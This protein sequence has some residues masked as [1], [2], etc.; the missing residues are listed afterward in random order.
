[1]WA[2]IIVILVWVAV[3]GF[4]AFGIPRYWMPVLVGAA[5]IALGAI[6]RTLRRRPWH[7]T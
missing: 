2:G 3:G 1:M 7:K 5:L 4:R 6:L